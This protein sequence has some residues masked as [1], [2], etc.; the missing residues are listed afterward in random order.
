MDV[1]K[2][3]CGD[4]VTQIAER[5]VKAGLVHVL[6]PKLFYA[7][8]RFAWDLWNWRNW[9]LRL[10]RLDDYIRPM[11]TLRIGRLQLFPPAS[12]LDYLPCQNKD[13]SAVV[14]L[15]PEEWGAILHD[16]AARTSNPKSLPARVQ[17]AVLRALL[18][19]GINP[20]GVYGAQ[21]AEATALV[22]SAPAF[23]RDG[24]L[25]ALEEK[26]WLATVAGDGPQDLVLEA[27]RLTCEVIQEDRQA[28]PTSNPK[29]RPVAG[30]STAVVEG[31]FKV[32]VQQLIERRQAAEED[33]LFADR[34][35]LLE[36]IIAKLATAKSFDEAVIENRPAA[37]VL[38]ERLEAL[39]HAELEMLAAAVLHAESVVPL[40]S[41]WLK[42]IGD[43]VSKPTRARQRR[44]PGDVTKRR[45]GRNSGRNA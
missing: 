14:L 28:Q 6:D 30:G 44:A 17:E 22:Q 15:T 27:K 37:E 41:R 9:Y 33:K 3:I 21:L 25:L 12:L 32:C 2:E 13:G 4:D 24:S 8:L 10:D 20:A 23:I 36:T 19:A 39:P 31:V 42:A 7:S 34:D 18:A 26:V 16:A 38:K 1:L 40:I 5:L 43:G 45:S 11:T 29:S 35:R